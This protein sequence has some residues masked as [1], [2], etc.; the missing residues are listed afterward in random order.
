MTRNEKIS[1]SIFFISI[2]LLVYFAF[3]SQKNKNK[4]IDKNRFSTVAKIYE[5][6]SKRS[7]IYAR[8]Y[9]YFNN[10]KHFSGEYVDNDKRYIINKYYRVELSTVETKYSR[11]YLDNEITDSSDIIKAGFKYN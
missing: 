2:S 4:I 5:I 8:Y 9:F 11:I 6:K 3:N 1:A 7:F 10:E